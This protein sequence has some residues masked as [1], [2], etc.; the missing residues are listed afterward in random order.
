MKQFIKAKAATC[1]YIIIIGGTLL[2]CVNAYVDADH[3]TYMMNHA[4]IA[5]HGGVQ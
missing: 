4:D 2:A 3:E 5:V 1:I